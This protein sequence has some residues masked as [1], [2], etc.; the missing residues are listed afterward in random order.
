M[1]IKKKQDLKHLNLGREKLISNIK[2]EFSLYQNYA[3]FSIQ[4]IVKDIALM[5]CIF[6]IFST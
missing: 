4:L 3:Q 1:I 6:E 2:N 5:F